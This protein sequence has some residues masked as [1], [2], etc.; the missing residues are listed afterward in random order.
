MSGE[1]K[2]HGEV[3][4]QHFIHNESLRHPLQLRLPRIKGSCL[5]TASHNQK[6]RV[7][8][9]LFHFIESCGLSYKQA[10]T[11][12]CVEYVLHFFRKLCE[13]CSVLA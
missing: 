13:L 9:G 4:W 12:C 10:T 6:E 2:D 1:E 11:M 8:F 5:R 7:F 3:A